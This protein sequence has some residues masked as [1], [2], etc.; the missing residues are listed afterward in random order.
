MFYFRAKA[1]TVSAPHSAV[2]N[3][4]WFYLS[5]IDSLPLRQYTLQCPFNLID[6]FF[7][8]KATSSWCAEGKCNIIRG[9][10]SMHC[11]DVTSAPL[12]CHWVN[13]L[14]DSVI[15]SVKHENTCTQS[16]KA[17]TH[18]HTLGLADSKTHTTTSRTDA[19]SILKGGNFIFQA[20]SAHICHR[21][22]HHFLT[23]I[24]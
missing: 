17:H 22:S 9:N 10:L 21:V 18:T 12:K 20:Q 4:Y 8:R 1:A 15:W 24:R 14:K 16:Q 5:A 2:D 19:L 11:R 6:F 13:V 23:H 3:L 7:L